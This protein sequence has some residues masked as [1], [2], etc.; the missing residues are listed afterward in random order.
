MNKQELITNLETS[1]ARLEDTVARMSA[2]QMTEPNAVG[3]W[4]VKDVLAH[5]AMCAARCVT[6]IYDAEQGQASDDIDPM[7]DNVDAQ[8]AED[9]EV[10]K[11]R[12]LERVLADFRGVHRQLL[13][14]LGGWDEAA[15][16]DKTRFAWLR[17]QS[18]GEFIQGEV[19]DHENDH[20]QDIA[21]WL[22]GKGV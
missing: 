17:G 4:S 7:F 14:R 20:R 18:L 2:Q 13:K 10:Q 11:D 3:D 19:A 21:Q 15:L 1:R 5:L 12:P 16:F 8:N 22:A 6:L 9:Y